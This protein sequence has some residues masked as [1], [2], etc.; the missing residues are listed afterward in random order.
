MTVLLKVNNIKKKF[1]NGS[2]DLIAVNDVSFN[3]FQNEILGIVGPSGSGK[4]TI[5][6]LVSFLSKPNEGTIDLHIEGEDVVKSHAMN[7]IRNEY[8]GYVFQDF[9]LIEEETVYNN[10]EIPL[11]YNK[12]KLSK[13]NKKMMVFDLL[14]QLGIPDKMNVKV[15]KLSGGERQRV[16]IARAL[17]NDPKI[18]IAD[19]PTGSLD[20]ENS[21]MIFE[22]LY[23]LKK[24]SQ[25]VIIVTHDEEIA[26]RCDRCIRLQ[27]GKIVAQT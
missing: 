27:D 6:N 19:E 24:N 7:Q 20:S 5:L 14:T 18:I 1:K 21:E 12:K 22:I 13:K 17:I 3:L 25:S 15:S 16:A 26:S 4:T 9:M 11:L 8:F 23:S 2:T 10:V